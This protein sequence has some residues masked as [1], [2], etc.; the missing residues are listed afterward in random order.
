M[1]KFNS[2]LR[3]VNDLYKFMECDVEELRSSVKI[4]YDSYDEF[5]N[6]HFELKA[7]R[8]VA[9]AARERLKIVYGDSLEAEQ[10]C[11]MLQALQKLDEARRG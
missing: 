5:E 1:E 7:L 8:E 9:E 3:V 6:L 2:L 10:P 4:I 11:R